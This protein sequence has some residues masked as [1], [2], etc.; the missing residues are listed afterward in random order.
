MTIILELLSLRGDPFTEILK[1][2]GNVEN[3]TFPTGFNQVACRPQIT[4]RGTTGWPLRV[5]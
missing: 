1:S 2:Y 4:E 5:M 3:A